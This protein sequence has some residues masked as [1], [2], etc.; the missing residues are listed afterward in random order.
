MKNDFFCNFI[1]IG[2][3]GAATTLRDL[4]GLDKR[5]TWGMRSLRWTWS[6]SSNHTWWRGGWQAW[7]MWEW[8]CRRQGRHGST[9]GI[10]RRIRPTSMMELLRG[11]GARSRPGSTILSTQR[12][13]TWY[14]H[15][16]STLSF[17]W[18]TL[19]RKGGPSS[20]RDFVLSLNQSRFFGRLL[21]YNRLR[22]KLK[23]S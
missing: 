14:R 13:R 20:K 7:I 4:L 3:L 22:S 10:R 6:L 12:R 9:S 15:A 11:V 19:V 17:V 23:K 5:L 21:G 2:C 18:R 16:L 8:L 1:I